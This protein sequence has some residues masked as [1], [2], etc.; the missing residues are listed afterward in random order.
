VSAGLS[1]CCASVARVVVAVSLVLLVPTC[2]LCVRGVGVA[3]RDAWDAPTCGFLLS[4][5]AMT[6]GPW[7]VKDGTLH[8]VRGEGGDADTVG[9]VASCAAGLLRA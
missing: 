3:R 7:S 9:D 2:R 4:V 5:A 6:P 8:G 1:C